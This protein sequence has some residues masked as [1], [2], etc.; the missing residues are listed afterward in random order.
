LEP[1]AFKFLASN[2]AFEA[3]GTSAATCKKFP[4]FTGFL[5]TSP[6]TDLALL[7]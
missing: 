2:L 6:M 7:S 5:Q 3:L 4:L 1:A